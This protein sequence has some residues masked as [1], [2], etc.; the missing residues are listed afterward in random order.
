VPSPLGR[1]INRF[2]AGLETPKLFKL[3]VVL[4]L[5]NVVIPDPIP[6]L[7]EILM[8]I[9]VVMLARRKKGPAPPPDLDYPLQRPDEPRA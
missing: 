3:A 2:L 9:A 5:M 6:L 1:A 7:D 8:G 4:F